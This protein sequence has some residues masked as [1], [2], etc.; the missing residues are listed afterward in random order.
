VKT[1][2]QLFVRKGRAKKKVRWLEVAF[3]GE[4]TGG[5]SGGHLGLEFHSP[6][7][8]RDIQ[9]ILHYCG[10]DVVLLERSGKNTEDDWAV[11]PFKDPERVK[12]SGKR[13]RRTPP[14]MR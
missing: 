12:R 2:V 14:E 1:N 3:H 10:V 13:G 11:I 6:V 8:P 7:T 9:T 5:V 4:G